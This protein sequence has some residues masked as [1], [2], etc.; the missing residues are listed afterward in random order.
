MEINDEDKVL[1]LLT[2][3]LQSYKSLVIVLIV[4]KETLKVK[5]IIAMILDDEKFKKIRGSNEDETFV[6]NLSYSR[7]NS[8]E[9]I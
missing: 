5:E 1:L 6:A 7:S 3:F 8:Y 4:G 2:S 9:N